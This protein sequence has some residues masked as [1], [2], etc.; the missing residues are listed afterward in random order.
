MSPGLQKENG[1]RPT[2]EET[3]E[4]WNAGTPPQD[5]PPPDRP[6]FRAFFS[7]SRPHLRS[8]SL[9]GGLL[10]SFFFSLW[11]SSRGILSVFLKARTLWWCF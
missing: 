8:F 7:L 5:P 6:K 2:L 9:S 1:R 4:R 3:P 11:G 10:V